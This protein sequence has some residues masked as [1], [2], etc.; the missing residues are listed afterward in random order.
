MPVRQQ[1]SERVAL[2][3]EAATEPMPH[4]GPDVH[5]GSAAEFFSGIGLV[6]VALEATGWLVEYS[7][8]I[9][10]MK[11]RIYRENYGDSDL[12]TRDIK[13]VVGN[14][15]PQVDLA[16]ASF[17]CID[18]SLAGNNEGLNG[19]HSS[20]LWEFLRVIDEMKS[21]RPGR[22]LIENVPGFVT[23][24]AGT[25]LK[26][27][28]MRLNELDYTCDLVIC[29]ARW[30][31][32]QSR[33]RLFIIAWQDGMCEA[34][35]DRA[36]SI[37]RPAAIEEFIR[38]NSDLNMASLECPRIP[39]DRPELCS[40]IEHLDH[41]DERWWCKE[42]LGGF[43][44][45]LSEINTRRLSSMKTANEKTWATAYRRTRRGQS[46]WE[47]RGDAIAGCLRTASGGSSK[48]A[49]VEAGNGAVNVRWMT[50]I[51]YS[52]LQGVASYRIPSTV[53]NNQALFGFGDAVCVP[54]V[55]WVIA[56]FINTLRPVDGELA[57]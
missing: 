33:R 30:F 1:S 13:C 48:Q 54:A 10:P 55:E 43:L 36:S 49:L 56:N 27:T 35:I 46:A 40:A 15:I 3:F 4:H 52:R 24:K 26:Q 47:I 28:V 22:L 14:E 25:D 53:S 38:K 2:E 16:T 44:A 6:R 11:Q 21:R 20:L 34:R 17:P 42:R 9:S 32:P 31:V 12:D 51:E 45:S 41:E 23:S 39:E 18:L 7:N 29:D 5:V 57:A 50:A 19:K 8:D 37:L